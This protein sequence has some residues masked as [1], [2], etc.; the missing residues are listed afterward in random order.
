ME[1]MR[2]DTFKTFE[3]DRWLMKYISVNKD[4]RRV[5]TSSDYSEMKPEYDMHMKAAILCQRRNQRLHSSD[6]GW[7]LD[8]SG[9]SLS[10]QSFIVCGSR[11]AAADTS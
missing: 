7:S 5:S 11:I 3:R 10:Y 1:H 4:G 9:V 6:R 2:V 8:Q